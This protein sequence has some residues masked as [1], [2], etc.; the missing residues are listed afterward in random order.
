MDPRGSQAAENG[1]TLGY[2]PEETS[3]K[4]TESDYN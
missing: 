3:S 2:L 4:E 1:S